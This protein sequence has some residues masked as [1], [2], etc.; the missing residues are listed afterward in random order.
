M[1]ETGKLT[2]T[3]SQE[4]TE[5][6]NEVTEIEEI[7]GD[8]LNKI[9]VEHTQVELRVDNVVE[10]VGCF[11]TRCEHQ[12]GLLK[13]QRETVC[14]LEADRDEVSP[15][16]P[17]EVEGM[18][19]V[20]GYTWSL[21]GMGTPG[22]LVVARIPKVIVPVCVV[23]SVS[24]ASVPEGKYG[25]SNMACVSACM[26]RVHGPIQTGDTN[27]E[28]RGPQRVNLTT[29]PGSRNGTYEVRGALRTR[30]ARASSRSGPETF[31][32]GRGPASWTAKMAASVR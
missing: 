27:G 8:E 10:L 1:T 19:D 30:P 24:G 14:S 31:H 7:E 3:K 29:A 26:E 22:L 21:G 25:V 12:D 28:P 20:N 2:E 23:K 17:C 15:V 9:K 32:V 13:E 4:E 6:I 11:V 16:E 18:S 5:V